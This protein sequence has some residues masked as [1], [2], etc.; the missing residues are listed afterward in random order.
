[1][2]SDLPFLGP[3]QS[4]D[5][6]EFSRKPKRSSSR[7]LGE[8]LQY[9]GD[10]ASEPDSHRVIGV[11]DHDQHV[12]SMPFV[13]SFH[14]LTYSVKNRRKIVPSCFSRNNHDSNPGGLMEN[15]KSRMKV[16]LNGISGEA[17]EGEIMAVLGAS[18]SG[19]STLIDALAD[20]IARES[21]KG[22]ITL[23]GDVLESKLLKVISA[24]VM[25]DDLLFPMLTVEETLMFSAEFRLP[26]TMSKSRKKARVQALIDQLGLRSAAKTV[27]GDEGHRGVSGGE[28]RR[29][30]IGTDIIHDPIVLFLDEPTSGLDSTSAYMVV[31]VL[32]RIA[33]SGS[34]VI[35]SIHQPSYRILSLLDRLIILSRGQTVFSGSP[36]HLPQFFAEFGNPIP[37]N[38]DKTEFALD[39]IRELESTP[40]GTNNLADFNKKWQKKKNPSFRNPNGPRLSL[41]DAISA[42]ISMGKLVSGA[43]NMDSNMVSVPKYANPFWKEMIVIANRSITN[44]RRAPELFG[45]RFG[46]V[47]VT[48]HPCFPHGKIHFHERNGLQRVPAFVLRPLP[49]NNLR[50]VP[51]NPVD[52]ICRHYLLGRRPIRVHI[53]FRVHLGLVKGQESSFVT[54]LSGI[55]FNLMMAYTVVV[56]ILAYFVLF[57]GFFITRDRIPSY[58]LWFHYLS[59]VKYPYQEMS[60]IH[61]LFHR[62]L[63]LMLKLDPAAQE[64]LVM[65]IGMAPL[66][67]SMLV[68]YLQGPVPDLEHIFSRYGRTKFHALQYVSSYDGLTVSG[69]HFRRVRDVDMKRD[70]AFVEFS[71]PRD[72]DDARYN[73]DGRDVDGRRIIVEFAKE[74]LVDLEGFESMWAEV[75]LQG[76]GAASIVALMAIGP[77][78]A[79]LE[80]GKISV[81]AVGKEVTLKGTARTVL[82]N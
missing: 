53:L 19:K 37:A 47:L 25:Q 1:M 82:R 44:S 28:R 17:R 32:Q 4:M 12:T 61:D 36:R 9:V 50:P 68:T 7:T 51:S 79:K 42:S 62:S 30:S 43:T 8:L 18:G 72:A 55:I 34:I 31:K 33:Q 49:R 10:H 69:N 38:E 24:Y 11:H 45:A 57:T 13:L 78:I 65:K 48:G 26:R 29:V 74:C 35:M 39:Y 23:N 56:A 41:K 80:T 5:L 70:Y 16:L 20:R 40:Q 46:A 64:C 14:N 6:Q 75:L 76:L 77:E 21:L 52:S 27:I 81:I 60:Y 3:R 15:N 71:D 67:A 54:F 2:A 59:L 73:L 22:T 66:L 58:W 63:L